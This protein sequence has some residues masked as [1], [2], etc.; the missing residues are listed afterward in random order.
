MRR[1]CSCQE[2]FLSNELFVTMNKFE[3][4]ERTKKFAHR[5]V[6]AGLALPDHSPGRHIG[7]QLIRCSTSVA[8]NYR[9]ACLSQS[10]ASLISK[11][12]IVVEETDETA[13]WIEFLMEEGLLS[14]RLV[15]K[16]LNE[17]R[18]LVSIFIAT[19]KTSRKNVSSEHI[20]GRISAKKLKIEN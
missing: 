18:E 20:S 11:V 5:C 10:K 13:F 2:R 1:K 9:A 17:A 12:G 8:A 19:Q 3:L 15:R 6:K 14:E 4:H 16:L 7:R